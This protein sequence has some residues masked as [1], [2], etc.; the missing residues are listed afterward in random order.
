MGKNEFH[1]GL[2]LGASAFKSLQW[3]YFTKPGISYYRG[4]MMG[5]HSIWANGSYYFQ[6]IKDPYYISNFNLITIGLE[7]RFQPSTKLD[8]R[9]CAGLE[10]VRSYRDR[11]YILWDNSSH[12]ETIKAEGVNFNFRIEYGNQL[13]ICREIV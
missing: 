13:K 2:I 4:L 7:Y 3:K 9:F 1:A 5:K 11:M 12:F 10:Y 8:L 6:R